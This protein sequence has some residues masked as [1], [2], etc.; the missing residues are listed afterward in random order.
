MIF[1]GQNTLKNILE[2]LYFGQIFRIHVRNDKLQSFVT[3][4]K[5]QKQAIDIYWKFQ[6]KIVK[7]WSWQ[8]SF[9]FLQ[10]FDD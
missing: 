4:T 1:F 10:K 3:K 2:I 5:L 8:Q 9:I 7:Q 6:T